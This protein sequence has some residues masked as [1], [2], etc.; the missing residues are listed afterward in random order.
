M[1]AVAGALL[2]IRNP[3]RSVLDRKTRKQDRIGNIHLL[4]QIQAPGT[5]TSSGMISLSAI[6]NARSIA[7]IS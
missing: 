3:E 4:I 2:R 1:I 7:P 6:L 5:G